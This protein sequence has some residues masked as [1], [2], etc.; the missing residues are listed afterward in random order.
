MQIKS[1][2]EY[3]KILDDI[4][5]FTD[6]KSLSISEL[7][8]LNIKKLAVKNYEMIEIKKYPATESLI[9]DFKNSLHFLN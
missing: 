5:E 6:Q 9:L 7:R 2:P 1:T 8:T 4:A 3:L